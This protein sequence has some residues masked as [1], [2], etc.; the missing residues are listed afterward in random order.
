MFRAFLTKIPV[1]NH[2][3]QKGWPTGMGFGRFFMCPVPMI[4]GCWLQW[5]GW[6]GGTWATSSTASRLVSHA[7]FRRFV[8]GSHSLQ[9][10]F[11]RIYSF[12]GKTLLWFK[13][14]QS[15]FFFST[16]KS[17]CLSFSLHPISRLL[18][19][20]NPGIK[21]L[22]RYVWTCQSV[23]GHFG[24]SCLAIKQPV[25]LHPLERKSEDQ[26]SLLQLRKCQYSGVW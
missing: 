26:K 14:G 6:H 15:P 4:W 9:L 2:H 21:S 18:G 11:G 19:I 13:S 20:S 8:D 12:Q 17:S 3:H 7:W 5:W 10:I 25:N 24:K 16:K 22:P 1:L 23:V